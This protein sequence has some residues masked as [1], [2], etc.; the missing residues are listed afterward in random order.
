[1]TDNVFHGTLNL[2]QPQPRDG[3]ET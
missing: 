2:N 1:M 3:H